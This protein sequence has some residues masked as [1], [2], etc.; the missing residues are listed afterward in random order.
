MSV[1]LTLEEPPLEAT[2]WTGAMMAK[3]AGVSV[4]SVQRVWRAHGLA[5]HRTRHFKLSND[6][7]F[8]DKLRDVVRLYVDPPAHA[9]V[10]SVEL[11]NAPCMTTSTVSNFRPFC[12]A[13][14]SV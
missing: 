6:P 1:A 4:S 5:P 8:I 3:A 11:P 10:L 7:K 14:G 2:H 9:I 13:R 12:G